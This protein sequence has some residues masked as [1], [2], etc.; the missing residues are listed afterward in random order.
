[1][2]YVDSEGRHLAN[3]NTLKETY[4]P[5]KQHEWLQQ[6]RILRKLIAKLAHTASA[7]YSPA[8]WPTERGARLVV[9]K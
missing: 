3:T 7:S 6:T 9:E 5:T 8:D 4:L 1:M 2:P